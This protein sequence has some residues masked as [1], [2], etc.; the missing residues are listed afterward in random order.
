V[1]QAIVN[2]IRANPVPIAQPDPLTKP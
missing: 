2:F 1:A